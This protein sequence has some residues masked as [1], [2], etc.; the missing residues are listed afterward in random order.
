VGAKFNV[1]TQGKDVEFPKSI[2]SPKG[3]G[4]PFSG[5]ELGKIG[6]LSRANTSSEV[7]LGKYGTSGSYDGPDGAG[8]GESG[9]EIGRAAEDWSEY[10]HEHGGLRSSDKREPDPK[11]PV[12]LEESR[13]KKRKQRRRLPR[14]AQLRLEIIWSYIACARGT[15]MMLLIS[16]KDRTRVYLC[17]PESPSPR[18]APVR[19]D[20]DGKRA[21]RKEPNLLRPLNTPQT[22][23]EDLKRPPKLDSKGRSA[24]VFLFNFLRNKGIKRITRVIADDILDSRSAPSFSAWTSR[25]MSS[26]SIN[27]RSTTRQAVPLTPCVKRLNTAI[28]GQLVWTSLQILSRTSIL[29]FHHTSR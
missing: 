18:I 5:T 7:P 15:M 14:R 13:A 6:P 19:I 2:T 4:G 24:M 21:A 25:S 20:P 3:L 11:T 9:I 16:F 23:S 26:R 17:L 10:P 1:A 12:A 8:N 28:N 22:I 29:P 27:L